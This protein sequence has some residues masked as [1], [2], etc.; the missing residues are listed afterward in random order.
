[1]LGLLLYVTLVPN[2]VS[3]SLEEGPFYQRVTH[4]HVHTIK[5]ILRSCEE[6]YFHLGHF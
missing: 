4:T 3:V 2:I 1:M 6:L 5:Y